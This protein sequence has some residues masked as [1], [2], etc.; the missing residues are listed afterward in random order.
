MPAAVLFKAT[1]WTRDQHRHSLNLTLLFH[2]MCE[3]MK[4]IILF[5]AENVCVRGC[6]CVLN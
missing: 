6:V 1:V 2:F 5:H 3:G 4:G